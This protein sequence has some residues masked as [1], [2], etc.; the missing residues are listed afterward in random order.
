MIITFLTELAQLEEPT[1][2]IN[3][4][5]EEIVQ[6]ETQLAE[7][8]INNACMCALCTS[9]TLSTVQIQCCMFFYQ[10]WGFNSFNVNVTVEDL[11]LLWP[12]VSYHFN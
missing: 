10:I 4:T 11:Y 7:V 3:S 5:A 9:C 12:D 2:A 8:Y 1:A 6:L